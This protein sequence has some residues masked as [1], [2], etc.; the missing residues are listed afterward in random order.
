MHA[1]A[2]ELKD[3]YL[4]RA[5]D[6]CLEGQVRIE[7]QHLCSFCQVRPPNVLRDMSKEHFIS[8]LTILIKVDID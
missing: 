4:T 3:A 2:K 1:R 8:S 6:A 7:R 5:L